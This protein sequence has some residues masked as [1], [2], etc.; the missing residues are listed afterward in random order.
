MMRGY[1]YRAGCEVATEYLEPAYRQA[2]I[3]NIKTPLACIIRYSA[4]IPLRL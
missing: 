4:G 1:L 3:C 2:V